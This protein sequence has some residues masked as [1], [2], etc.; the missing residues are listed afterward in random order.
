MPNAILEN[1]RKKYRKLITLLNGSAA[2]EKK[3]VA[4]ISLILGTCDKTT[5]K[6]LAH[7]EQLSLEQLLK[8]GEY[9]NIPDTDFKESIPYSKR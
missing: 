9:L 1:R 6:Y 2:A 3:G 7:P 8:L 4:H 5:K